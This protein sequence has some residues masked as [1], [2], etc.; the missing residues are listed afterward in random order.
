MHVMME[1]IPQPIRGMSDDER[2][3][4][5]LSLRYVHLLQGYQAENLVFRNVSKFDINWSKH[6]FGGLSDYFHVFV[7]QKSAIF[8]SNSNHEMHSPL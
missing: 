3:S 7:P 8:S 4:E 5:D 6:P 1:I 2:Q